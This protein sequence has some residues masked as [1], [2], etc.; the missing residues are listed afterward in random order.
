MISHRL[1]EIGFR[2]AVL[3]QAG[4]LFLSLTVLL[5]AQ[6]SDSLQGVVPPPATPVQAQPDANSYLNSPA[7]EDVTDSP[8]FLQPIFAKGSP[9]HFGL[10]A[11]EMYDDNIF[12][13]PNK[14]G[15]YVTS[16]APH[17]D[18]ELG[19]RTAPHANYFNLYFAPTFYLY[20]RNPAQDR[21][22]YNADVYYQHQWT[23]LTLGLEQ[24]Y[25][26]LTDTDIDIGNFATRDIY[27]TNFNASYIYNG[28]LTLFAKATQ[29]ITNYVTNSQVSTNEWIVDTHFLYQL[30][31]K[32]S[33]GAG[34]QVGFIDIIGAPNEVYQSLLGHL[35]YNPEGKLSV[36]FAGGVKYLQNEGPA[37]DHVLPIFDFT[38]TYTPHDGTILTLSASRETEPSYGTVGQEI[39]NTTA[40]LSLRQRFLQDCYFTVSGGYTEAMYEFGSVATVGTQRRDDYYFA[41]VGVEWDPRTWLQVA[42]N[43]ERS[44]D[45]S[46]LPQNTYNDNQLGVKASVNF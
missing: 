16:I 37:P 28:K 15:D 5:S 17:V 26:H 11:G 10:S 42:A 7:V 43:Y 44:A 3:A 31:P 1:S 40:Q 39:L 45:N 46:N 9:L 32:L 29:K 33:V 12:I 14:V 34:P 4:G 35:T 6:T 36:T 22:N 25:L 23:R 38:G 18:Y 21:Q 30:A 27:T 2:L 41:N 8:S 19:D 24:Q 20:D 13:S